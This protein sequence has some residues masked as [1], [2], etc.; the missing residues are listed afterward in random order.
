M[1]DIKLS[2]FYCYLLNNLRFRDL[3]Y[4]QHLYQP[5]V[6]VNVDKLLFD[7]SQ[8]LGVE[9]SSYPD[10]KLKNTTTIRNITRNEKRSAHAPDLSPMCTYIGEGH[11]TD[12]SDLYLQ[13]TYAIHSHLKCVQM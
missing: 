6:P 2:F 13:S 12:A 5:L 1:P 9:E 8:Q 4:R 3:H 10:R 7:L 11:V